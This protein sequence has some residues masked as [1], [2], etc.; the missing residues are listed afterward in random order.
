MLDR[1]RDPP[2]GRLREILVAARQRQG[3][4]MH[5]RQADLPDVVDLVVV[6]VLVIGREQDQ[7]LQLQRVEGLLNG[8]RRRDRL[9][10][11]RVLD[12]APAS[13]H[14]RPVPPP[15]RGRCNGRR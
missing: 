12:R 7:P 4:V 13:G 15:S 6:G 10:A 8:G 2:L 14:R 11:G 3:D 1:K 5:D 9:D